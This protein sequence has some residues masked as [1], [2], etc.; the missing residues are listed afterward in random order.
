MPKAQSRNL[1]GVGRELTQGTG[2]TKDSVPQDEAVL[3]DEALA[4]IAEGHRMEPFSTSR[5]LVRQED[6]GQPRM[7]A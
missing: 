7:G 4:R 5:K 2:I 1:I 3:Q 6:L